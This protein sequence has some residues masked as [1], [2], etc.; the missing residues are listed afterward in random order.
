MEYQEI[1]RRLAPCGLDCTRCADYGD[2]EIRELSAI[3]SRHLAGYSR[4]AKMKEGLK[5]VFAGY[6][7][8][9][10]VLNNFTQAACSGCRG[11]NILCPLEC[12]PKTCTR[13]KGLDF[14]FQCGDFPCEREI[15]ARLRD[16]WLEFN[17]R[18]RE[19]GVEEFYRER[20]S[21]PRY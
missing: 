2:G 1:V 12:S 11:D 19:V 16:R 4:V 21:L 10:A 20:C 17:Q 18:M 13:E 8:F 15:D 5:P 9:E 14:C 3:L 7:Q 6:Q